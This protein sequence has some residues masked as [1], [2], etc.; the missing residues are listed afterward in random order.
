MRSSLGDAKKRA[1]EA[2]QTDASLD[3]R[4]GSR[5]IYERSQAVREYVLQRAAEVCELCTQAA[6]FRRASGSPYLEPHHTTRVSDGGPD[7]PRFVAA[8]Y[9]LC[10]RE[11]HYGEN[12][13][14]KN[15][16]LQERLRLIEPNCQEPEDD[17]G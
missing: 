10:H 16:L 12:G 3:S 7:H 14:A 9:P 2:A 15:S 13:A 17:V 8:L 4:R 1:I 6:S 5:T 11:V